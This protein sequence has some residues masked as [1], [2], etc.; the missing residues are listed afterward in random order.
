MLKKILSFSQNIMIAIQ[1]FL[2]WLYHNLFLRLWLIFAG[3]IGIST[4]STCPC[5]GQ[6]AAA[7]PT[8]FSLIAGLAGMLA[9]LGYFRKKFIRFLKKKSS[10]SE[11]G[12]HL[13]FW[14]LVA[15]I[16]VTLS[17]FGSLLIKK[18]MARKEWSPVLQKTTKQSRPTT[19]SISNITQSP[20]AIKN[21]TTQEPLVMQRPVE[22]KPVVKAPAQPIPVKRPKTNAN[23][24]TTLP[25]TTEKTISP[26]NSPSP[27][28]PRKSL[29]NDKLPTQMRAVIN[30]D[31]SVEMQKAPEGLIR[32]E[33]WNFMEL[34]DDIYERINAYRGK[35]V[36]IEGYVYRR[37]DFEP[38]YFVTAR[39]Y[40]WCCTFD[41]APVGPLC[42][43][44]RADELKDGDWINVEG[45]IEP[46]FFHDTFEDASD[47][48]PLIKV[49][50]VERIPQLKNP[51]VYLRGT[52]PT[53]RPGHS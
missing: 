11:T 20:V 6:P 15:I 2:R 38:G 18:P 7:C 35:K 5:C 33:T 39:L 12:A 13:I 43:W 16:L 23:S 8:G 3:F 28:E 17:I 1:K 19:Q 47:D 50:K 14:G 31:G 9:A 29:E 48:I 46:F 53:L 25:K 51:Y 49:E 40:M 34:N 26:V 45:T 4:A 24:I 42:K 37:K 21:I 10:L 30:P 52:R 44:N 27:L 41:A 22:Q 36:E 32:Y